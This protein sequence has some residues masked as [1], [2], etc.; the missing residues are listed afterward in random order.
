MHWFF[1][2]LGAGIGGCAR[3]FVSWLVTGLLGSTF[4]FG[5]LVVNVSGAYLIGFLQALLVSK[6]VN[7]AVLQPLI[8]TG[9]MGGF[10]TFSTL[11]LEAT[12]L[13]Q[14]NQLVLMMAYIGSSLML[15]LL[16][17]DLGERTYRL[18]ELW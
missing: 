15:G 13:I 3:F 8:L 11:S 10:T 5:T 9:F 12:K 14:S 16:A 1:I 18:V 6:Q 17:V 2:F 7:V 4:P